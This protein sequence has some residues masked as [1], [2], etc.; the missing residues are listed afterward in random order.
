[1]VPVGPRAPGGHPGVRGYSQT[2]ACL[3]G[4]P[5][6][7]GLDQVLVQGGQLQEP[8]LSS[9]PKWPFAPGVG[10]PP[11][12]LGQVLG[13]PQAQEGLRTCVSCRGLH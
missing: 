1:M 6:T 3:P 12:P 4:T 9:V 2:S 10:I 13:L 11:T 8:P 5:L 7:L